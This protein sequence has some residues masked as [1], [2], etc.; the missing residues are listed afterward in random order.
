MIG[1]VG[2]PL[3][4]GI[5][6][7]EGPPGT[8]ITVRGENLGIDA[9]D[10]IGL[11]ICGVDCLLS[12]EWKSSSKI[13]ARTGP[14]KGKGDVIITTRSGG[15]GSSSIGFRGYF[16]QIGPLQESAVWIDESQT[17][18]ANLA[19]GRPSSP[20]SPKED[21]D[22]L[23]L[24]DEGDG[25]KFTEEELLEIFPEASGNLSLEN[26]SPVWY[27]LENHCSASFDDLKAGLGYLQR[28]AS[29]RSQGPIA[30][31]KSNLST[32][33]EC[34]DSL[35]AM[36]EKFTKDDLRIDCMNSYAVLL[37]QA[38]SCADGLFQEVLGRKDKA[39]STR[40]A[41]SVLQKFRF[42][43]YMP[44]NI[45]RNIQR[46]DF[47]IVI[48]DYEKVKSLFAETEVGVFKKVYEEVENKIRTFCNMLHKKLLDPKIGLDEQKKLIRYLISLEYEGD[49]AWECLDNQLQNIIS[50]LNVCKDYH[51]AVGKCIFFYTCFHTSETLN[52]IIY[53][54]GW[55]FKTPQKVLFIE[56]L[57]DIMM[58]KFPDF[59][60]L[61]QAYFSGDFSIKESSGY[62]PDSSKHAKL[63]VSYIFTMIKELVGLYTAFVRAAILPES[64]ED[65]GDIQ[66]E[67]L[68]VW[69]SRRQDIS[70]A[71]LPHCVRHIRTSTSTLQDLDVH[72]EALNLVQELAFDLRTHCMF[73]LL[74]QAI[75]DVKLLHNKETWAIEYGD[76]YGGSTQL[77]VLFENIVNETISHLHEVV[78][79]NKPGEP[80]IFSQ[81]PIQKEATILCTQL[82]QAFALCMEQLSFSPPLHK[83]DSAH[84]ISIHSKILFVQDKRLVIMLSNCAHTMEKT[85]PRIIENLNKHGYVEMNKALKVT[86]QTYMELDQ[87]L[88]QA[89]IEQKTDPIIGTMEPNMYKSGFNWK[90]WKHITGVRSYLKEVI[91]SIIEVHAEVFSISP[92]FITRVMMKVMEAVCEE[93]SR[94]IQCVTAF[95]TIGAIQA[96]LELKALESIVVLYETKKIR[97]CFKEAYDCLPALSGEGKQMVDKL[98]SEFQSD[99]KIQLMCFQSDDNSSVA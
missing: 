7:K 26:F 24:S 52:N 84:S 45:E 16:L 85:V 36:Y 68:G 89:Y 23:G 5:S 18:P 63:R 96:K 60:K 43:F 28:K 82:L 47:N 34:L 13:I 57:T 98:L 15:K 56:D 70:G 10:L 72:G 90:T 3:V 61:G 40:N 88:F 58:E 39:D 42:L 37:M 8:R 59:W 54:E 32:I 77:P 73:T 22:P 78:V 29:Q 67:K 49:P 38:K 30:I 64:L 21:E 50:A 17:V 74:K 93:I 6:P 99:M 31:V 2:A 62:K 27:L 14:G 86:Q 9:R 35:A 48:N 55:K 81:R 20:M 83:I 95:G 51:I 65:V 19:H 75:I 25:V 80:E 79:L 94:I 71:W 12:A 33:L 1:S 87:K 11:K 69:P 53:I 92:A 4:T 97:G 46:G 76:E 66:L 41:L 91:I 44:Y